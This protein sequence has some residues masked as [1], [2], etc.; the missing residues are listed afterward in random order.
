MSTAHFSALTYILLL[1]PTSI[2]FFGLLL[3]CAA[4]ATG[5]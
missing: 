2:A 3:L 4:F 5:E 1:I